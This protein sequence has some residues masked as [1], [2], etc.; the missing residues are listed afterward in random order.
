MGSEIVV[1]LDDSPSSKLALQWAAQQAK[2]TDAVLRAVHVFSGELGDT[3]RQ[4]I[5][6]V[7]EAVSPRPN[8]VLEFLGGYSGEVLVR[9]SKDA[10]LLVVGTREHGQRLVGSVCHYCVSHAVC[11][12]V[13]VPSIDH[14]QSV[15]PAREEQSAQTAGAVAPESESAARETSGVG[16]SRGAPVVAGVDGSA[17][18]LAAARYAEAAAE[19]RGRDLVL[20]HAFPPPPPMTARGMVA[21]LSAVAGGSREVDSHRGRAAGNIS[22]CSCAQPGRAR[23][24]DGRT[25]NR[26]RTGRDAGAR[27]RRRVMGRAGSSGSDHLTGRATG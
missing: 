18:S 24:C 17:E 20:V 15:G 5:A 10:Q 4:A 2:S 6:A 9:Q 23:R 27:P 22:A 26:C 12:V 19:M 13:A 1:G 14:D 7:F 25:E 8:W 11:P 3:Y 21:A 16:T